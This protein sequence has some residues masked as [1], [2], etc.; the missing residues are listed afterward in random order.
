[1]RR[2]ANEYRQDCGKTVFSQIWYSA[3]PVARPVSIPVFQQIVSVKYL[4]FCGHNMAIERNILR[5]DKKR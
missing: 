4:T 1:L 3:R 5:R 2:V